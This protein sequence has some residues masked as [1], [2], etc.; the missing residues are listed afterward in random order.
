[1]RTWGDVCRVFSGQPRSTRFSASCG[2]RLPT[3][4]ALLGQLHRHLLST[5]DGEVP[6][7]E[8][9]PLG[10]QLGTDPVAL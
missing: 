3:R 10:Q 8:R 1:M 7:V 9:D 6:Q 2:K 5:D 4:S